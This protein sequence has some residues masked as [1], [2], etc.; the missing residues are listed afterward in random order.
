[1]PTSF[2]ISSTKHTNSL[3][4]LLI[5]SS[6]LADLLLFSLNSPSSILLFLFLDFLL[7]CK[8]TLPIQ[9]GSLN[10]LTFPSVASRCIAAM[11]YGLTCTYFGNEGN[12]FDL[13]MIAFSFRSY[14][15]KNLSYGTIRSVCVSIVKQTSAIGL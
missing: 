12:V 11:F 7:L 5:S 1:M 13:S 4:Y 9:I 2:L 10:I 3:W 14:K 15:K 8:T 6:I